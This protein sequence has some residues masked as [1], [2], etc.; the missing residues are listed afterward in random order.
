MTT[1]NDR[2]LD[3]ALCGTGTMF[4]H[5]AEGDRFVFNPDDAQRPYAIL[6]KTK[7][8]YR[9]E[10][11]GRKWKTGARTAVH[12]LPSVA[13]QATTGGQAYKPASS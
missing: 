6:I 1:I 4:K 5:L 11:G 13:P 12:P 2:D 10:V 3:A 7:N 8:G 9:H